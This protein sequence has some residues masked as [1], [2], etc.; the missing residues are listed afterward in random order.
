MAK[1]LL[2]KSDGFITA[3]IG[4]EE[5]VIDHIQR[6]KTHANLDDSFTH[7]TLN[8]RNGGNGNIKR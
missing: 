1:E 4:E 5:Y 8:L 6:V 2:D 3:T 7:F